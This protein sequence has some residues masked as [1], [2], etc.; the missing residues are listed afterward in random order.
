MI[1]DLA[2][3]P[4]AGE[5]SVLQG[6]LGVTER[7]A[8]KGVVRFKTSKDIKV[9]AL[10]LTLRGVLRTALSA[11]DGHFVAHQDIL[12]HSQ[13]LIDPATAL[14]D[15]LDTKGKRSAVVVRKGE[16]AYE[17][18]IDIPPEVADM[19]PGSFSHTLPAPKGGAAEAASKAAE[20]AAAEVKRIRTLERRNTKSKSPA[21]VKPSAALAG[22]L[23]PLYDGDETATPKWNGARV[24]Y[25]LT[26]SLA[27]LQTGLLSKPV[28]M[29]TVTE[30]VDFPRIDA[31]A[32]ARSVHTNTGRLVQGV[33]DNLEFK[34]EV[35]R[36]LFSLQQP[37]RIDVH[38]LTPH[39]HQRSIVQVS[40]HI[41]QI[42]K[43]RAVRSKTADPEDLQARYK[44]RVVRTVL[45][46]DQLDRPSS[47]FKKFIANMRKRVEPWSGLVTLTIDSAHRKIKHDPKTKAIDAYQSFDSEF[48]TVTHQIEVRV[49]LSGVEELVVYTVPVRL[50]DI[51]S[52]TKD[53]VLKNADCL[54][55]GDPAIGNGEDARSG[56]IFDEDD[57]PRL[58]PAIVQ[59]PVMPA[60]PET[61]LPGEDDE[62]AARASSPVPEQVQDRK[63]MH[64]AIFKEE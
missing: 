22:V 35:D 49:K 29:Y 26:A 50:L 31:M 28:R 32:V 2:I 1:D 4:L 46:S 16:P 48:I 5:K 18:D 9:L 61:P 36:T 60:H 54:N 34:F 21:E 30:E 44:Q 33:D 41:V 3:E 38:S 6:F 62:D 53:W 13:L 40:V 43:L 19:L 63:Q 20:A 10:T 45:A 8:L 64:D 39:E 23:A 25:T 12:A 17:F 14:P 57:L 11:D 58:E 52:E 27:V 59:P 15:E 24:I 51:D 7:A 42:E 56:Y 47:G 37:V 55:G